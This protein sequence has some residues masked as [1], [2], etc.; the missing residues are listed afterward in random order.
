MR[1]YG[2]KYDNLKTKKTRIIK[3]FGLCKSIDFHKIMSIY[4]GIE[5]MIIMKDRQ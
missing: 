1:K 5:F 2:E 4:Q 3:N